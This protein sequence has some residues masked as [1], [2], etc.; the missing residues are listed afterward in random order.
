VVRQARQQLT[1]EG[2]PHTRLTVARRAARL[3]EDQTRQAA[4]PPI[5]APGP[6]SISP[7]RR[8]A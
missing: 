2:T 3:L 1:D 7:A 8:I 6:S 4:M 5:T